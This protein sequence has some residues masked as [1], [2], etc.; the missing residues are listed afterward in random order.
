M[1]VLWK[2]PKTIGLL[3]VAFTV[4]SILFNKIL[5]V[6]LATFT[7]MIALGLVAYF[8]FKQTQ[9]DHHSMNQLLFE[10]FEKLGKPEGLHLNPD[11]IMLFHKLQ[12]TVNDLRSDSD[13]KNVASAAFHAGQVLII[14]D[15][16]TKV[17]NTIDNSTHFENALTHAKTCINLVHSCIYSST[18]P[19]ESDVIVNILEEIR[20]ILDDVMIDIH[21]Q[22]NKDFID[23]EPNR[24]SEFIEP[25]KWGPDDDVSNFEFYN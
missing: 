25:S 4:S 13:N 10:N 8:V 16:M 19:L 5:K 12:V 7:T 22:I 24:Y 9:A 1:D 14:Q 17:D 23:N 21:R 11:L 2:D 20:G 6:N 18:H 3:L 15:Y